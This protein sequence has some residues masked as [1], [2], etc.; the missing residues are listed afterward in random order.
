[1]GLVCLIVSFICFFPVLVVAGVLFSSLSSASRRA[2]E[3]GTVEELHAKT[4]ETNEATSAVTVLT[5][6]RPKYTL[7]EGSLP[8]IKKTDLPGFGDWVRAIGFVAQ[9]GVQ[10]V[11]F[12]FVI[13]FCS[14]AFCFFL[15]VLWAVLVGM[16]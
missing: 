14:V 7:T 4:V 5:A 10:W 16:R 2:V 11:E 3:N 12:L 1:M 8:S 15:L 6:G 13:G 9:F